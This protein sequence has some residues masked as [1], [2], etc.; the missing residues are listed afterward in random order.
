MK[1]LEGGLTFAEYME[2]SN[3]DERNSQVIAYDNTKL[4]EKCKKDILKIS[5]IVN[6]IVFSDTYCPDCTVT[7]PFIKKMQELNSNI[8]V[9]IYPLRGN[10]ELLQNYVGQAR[11]PTVITF[12][13]D[14]LPKGAYVEIP[15]ALTAKIA[16]MKVEIQKETI[17]AYRSGKYNELVEEE[18]LDLIR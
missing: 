9:K 4:S 14:W 6:V 11:I 10:E 1:N 15:K 7:L 16:R 8:K 18:L 12:N 3:E 2:K 17:G 5:E 13:K